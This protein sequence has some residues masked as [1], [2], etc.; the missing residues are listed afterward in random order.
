MAIDIETMGNPDNLKGASALVEVAAI[1]RV[2]VLSSGARLGDKRAAQMERDASRQDRRG[3]ADRAAQLK[4]AAAAMRSKTASMDVQREKEQIR[5]LTP[6]G[7]A[8]LVQGRASKDGRGKAGLIVSLMTP[9]G[10]ILDQTKSGEGGAFALKNAQ[11][12]NDARVVITDIDGTT[13]GALRAPKLSAGAQVFL[14]MPVER[15]DIS[16]FTPTKE[17]TTAVPDLVGS[18]L[19]KAGDTLGDDLVMGP[20]KL[21]RMPAQAGEVLDQSPHPQIRVALGTVV[22]LQVATGKSAPDFQTAR[23]LIRRHPAIVAAKVPPGHLTRAETEAGMRSLKDLA[24]VSGMTTDDVAALIP[25]RRVAH[26]TAW[27][28]AVRDV[29]AQF[30]G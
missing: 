5:P 27:Q 11:P 22:T 28:A 13:L 9:D 30:A 23:E 29:L 24:Q 10:T 2:G 14:D 6:T 25:G 26:A 21:V 1:A 20:V 19:E 4:T 15:L 18:T 16:P 12:V 3:K 8:T 17:S 7:D